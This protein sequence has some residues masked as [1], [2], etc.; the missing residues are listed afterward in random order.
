MLTRV[1][2]SL[3]PCVWEH[4]RVGTRNGAKWMENERLRDLWARTWRWFQ[5]STASVRIIYLALTV[6]CT[7]FSIK[8]SQSISIHFLQTWSL[9]Y[10]DLH[11]IAAKS[12]LWGNSDNV[13]SPLIFITHTGICINNSDQSDNKLESSRP[14]LSNIF[15]LLYFNAHHCA[16]W[17]SIYPL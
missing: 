12:E 1:S 2:V 8:D 4:G 5:V 14:G 7:L 9:C 3:V 6:C 17:K 15:M 16:M 11:L 10:H 13:S